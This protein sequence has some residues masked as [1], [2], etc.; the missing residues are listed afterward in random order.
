M[1]RSTEIFAVFLRF[2]LPFFSDTRKHHFSV[3]PVETNFTQ[4]NGSAR[5]QILVT[6]D[7][8][9][10]GH[11]SRCRADPIHLIFLCLRWR[12]I[13]HKGMALQDLRSWSRQTSISLSCR[14][15]FSVP[16]VETNFPRARIR[17]LVSS[18]RLAIPA[19]TTLRMSLAAIP[20]RIHRI[21]S[22]L[23]S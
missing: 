17:V 22:E 14:S 19:R 2:V 18:H 15:N 8:D 21:S 10:V 13:F 7:L 6:S 9:L 11:R 20:Q 12:Q 4:A 5:L 3:P 23:R 1:L 16:P